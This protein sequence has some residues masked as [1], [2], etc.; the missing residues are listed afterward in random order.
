MIVKADLRE[1]TVASSVYDLDPDT[2]VLTVYP[3]CFL[4]TLIPGVTYHPDLLALEFDDIRIVRSRLMSK[5]NGYP[6]PADVIKGFSRTYV[7]KYFTF[8]IEDMPSETDKRHENSRDSGSQ[9]TASSE[10]SP[11][12]GINTTTDVVTLST[13]SPYMEVNF[14]GT[15]IACVLST[16]CCYAGLIMPI[17]SLA[18]IDIDIGMSPIDHNSSCPMLICNQG[19]SPNITWVA[20]IW[21]L[22]VS[23]GYTL[24]GR[25]SDIFG[26]RWLF[27]GCSIL[28]T[29][30]CIIASRAQSVNTLIGASI[31]IGLAASGQLSVNYV[32]GEL[33]PVRH[34][35]IASGI[36]SLSSFPISGLGSYFARLFIVHTAAGWRWDYYLTIMLSTSK[37]ACHFEVH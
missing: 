25:V 23:I 2:L 36:L 37:P 21:T 12:N 8:K 13:K 22:C 15:Y 33:V 6:E 17:T 28:A 20:L 27:I 35:F 29:T 34:R 24:V 31:L 4:L 16:V 3:I 5:S 1:S 10:P 30:G 14:I 18:F 26:R 19:P 9:G 7:P 11:I 32:V